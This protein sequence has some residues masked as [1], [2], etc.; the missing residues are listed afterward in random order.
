MERAFKGKMSFL[1][2][3]WFWRVVESNFNYASGTPRL[4]DRFVRWTT[5]RYSGFKEFLW[6]DLGLSPR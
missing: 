4:R 1:T 5:L 2:E 6:N 3:F